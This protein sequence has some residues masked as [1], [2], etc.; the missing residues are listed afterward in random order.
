M[1]SLLC[2]DLGLVSSPP[3]RDTFLLQRLSGPPE[4]A[5]R[6]RI[7]RL[8]DVQ[9][10][11]SDSHTPDSGTSHPYF[12]HSPVPS[13]YAGSVS[14]DTDW[15]LLFPTSRKLAHSHE[16]PALSDAP[17]AYLML[18][19]PEGKESNHAAAALLTRHQRTEWKGK[20]EGRVV[21]FSLP[22]LHNPPLHLLHLT[23]AEWSLGSFHMTRIVSMPYKIR[24]AWMIRQPL[25][26][27]EG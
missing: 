19:R 20:K 5:W 22:G 18:L 7:S 1:S 15:H 25:V 11:G 27:L 26:M 12:N 10:S 2:R 4:M 23:I 3:P 8:I 13:R 6:L 9:Q 21:P 16:K 24:L 17:P 14:R